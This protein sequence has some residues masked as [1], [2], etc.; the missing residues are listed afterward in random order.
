[1]KSTLGELELSTK[2]AEKLE[3]LPHRQLSPHLEKCCL[4]LSAT[5]SYEQAEQDIAYLTGIR[6]PAKT[7]QRL[8]HRQHFE[9]PN[10]EAEIAELS[11]DGGKVR[12]RTPLGLE[13]QWR[14]Y[15]AIATDQGMLA[16]FQN[17]AQLTDWVNEQRLSEV[18]VCLGDGHDGIWNII[19]QIGSAEQRL[20]ILDWYHLVENLH[21]VGGSIKRL[22][23]AETLLW[24]GQL[25]AAIALFSECQRKQAKNF[26]EYLRKHQHR[27]V[28]YE[29]FQAEGLY[30]IG[31]GAVESAIKQIGGRVQIS[32]AQWKQE[33]VP[34]VLAHRCA[35][36]NGLIGSPLPETKHN[37]LS[38]R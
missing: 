17:N 15:K 37:C 21:K 6:V 30:S 11:V 7:Q 33:N 31:S 35:Y 12:V 22:N 28:N 9:L 19:T 1:L 29:Y 8:V 14:D 36:L 16:N 4:R 27:I 13:C 25:E 24:K 5:V 10:V 26:C 38:Q 18:V 20:E 32:G 3:V 2:Q 23:Q 34:Q